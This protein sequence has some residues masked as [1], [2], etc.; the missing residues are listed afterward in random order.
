MLP[1]FGNYRTKKNLALGFDEPRAEELLRLRQH[2]DLV[3]NPYDCQNANP[4]AQFA[5]GDA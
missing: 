1:F 3:G 5:L 4:E 2:A